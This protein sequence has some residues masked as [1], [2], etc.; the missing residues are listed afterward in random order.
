MTDSSDH[1]HDTGTGTG[2]VSP[3]WKYGSFVLGFGL[4]LAVW[5]SSGPASATAG[6]QSMDE[7][8]TVGGFDSID[9]EAVLVILDSGG[10]RVGVLPMKV[11]GQPVD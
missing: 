2:L 1:Q 8:L 4:V 7:V 11:R 5:G 9:G 10:E 3:F 6:E